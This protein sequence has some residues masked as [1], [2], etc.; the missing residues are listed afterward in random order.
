MDQEI[1]D[2]INDIHEHPENHKHSY[3]DL[4]KCSLVKGILDLALLQAHQDFVDLGSNG[5]VK[6][7]TVEGPCACGAWHE[8]S[9]N[10]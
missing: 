4:L 8:K 9:E 10:K 7:D 6:C 1:I 2:R 3:N 5:G